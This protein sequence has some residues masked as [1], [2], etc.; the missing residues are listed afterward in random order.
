MIIKNIKTE[1]EIDFNCKS[2][3]ILAQKLVSDP[4]FKVISMSN[5]E[6][7]LLATE[8]TKEISIEDKLLGK[9]EPI[10]TI[11]NTITKEKATKKAKKNS[12]N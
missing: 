5:E 8:E 7:E 1:V 2:D 10:V 11:L 4:D 6:K 3:K 12:T 9:E